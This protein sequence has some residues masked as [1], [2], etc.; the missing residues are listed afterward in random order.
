MHANSR[1]AP[2]SLLR[3]L[4]ALT[5]LSSGMFS[6]S[7]QAA[8][9]YR[10]PNME[11][12]IF[13]AKKIEIDKF[14]KAGLVASLVSVAR[15]Y[16]EDEH[17]VDFALRSNALAIAGRLDPDSD[18]FIT[19]RDQLSENGRTIAEDNASQSRA[20]SLIFSGAR[21]LIRKDSSDNKQCAAYCL[22][23]A[24]RTDPNGKY[25]EKMR[26]LQDGLKKDNVTA[27]WV[28]MLLEGVEPRNGIAGGWGQEDRSSFEER[29]ELMPGGKADKF[30]NKQV[31]IFGLVVITLDNGKHAGSA[32]SI[33]AS[34]LR[35]EGVSGLKFKL[36]QKVGPMMANSLESIVSFLQVTYEDTDL[37][38]SGY[39]IDIVFEDKDTLTDGPSA[40]TAM[41]LMLESLFTGEEI[42]PKFACT[43]GITPNGKVTKI[44][45][46]AAKIR[47]ATR[48][49]C[50]IVG[51]P[52]GNAAGVADNLVLHGIGQLLDI[53][54]FGMA[55]IEQARAI[56]RK[57]KTSE[58]QDTLDSFGAI[59]A[60]IKEKGDDMI[61]NEAVQK[62]L[63]AVVEK[64][65]NHLSAKFLLQY[66]QGT[67]PTHLSVGGS[68]QEIDT[69]A[70]GVI[71]SAQMMAWRD[72]YEHG[73]AVEETAQEAV[74]VLKT[75]E[76]KV[77]ER[78]NDYLEATMKLCKLVLAGKEDDDE[79]IFLKRL[80]N[81]W[82]SFESKHKKLMDDPELQ[83]E[84][85]D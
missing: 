4:I 33:I 70:S 7:L 35:E 78:M 47:G 82:E 44:G 48:R 32:S 42:D 21:A 36:N 6:A 16:N 54:I 69:N 39:T 58:V 59:A 38:P 20:A 73:K 19:T 1:H 14:A 61:K 5:I 52:E 76:G 65:P 10:P 81:A 68:F 29:E 45:G 40:G 80:E 28:G 25:A 55:D 75:L 64:M 72:K 84:L 53:Q 77:D 67:A 66:A 41:S 31:A 30:K 24:L 57:S 46:V 71:R 56:S 12:E 62:K 15:D 9:L 26:D 34:A 3:T 49:N 23:I 79:E 18:K 50:N 83:E 63:E 74:N 37:V 51:V 43:G 2:R 13:A 17:K 11:K 85:R 8:G 22:D 27:D 60:I